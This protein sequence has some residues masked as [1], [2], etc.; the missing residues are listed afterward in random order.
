[1]LKAA[2]ARMSR[3]VSN[4]V[5]LRGENHHQSGDVLTFRLSDGLLRARVKG[6][7]HQIYDV[8]MD[9]KI[10]PDAAS[11]CGCERKVNCEHAV[12]AL[13]ALHARETGVDTSK[14]S[15]Q[16]SLS[17]LYETVIKEDDVKWYSQSRSEG[18]DFFSYHLG[19]L[20]DKQPVSIVPLVA[21]LL[22]QFGDALESRDDTER[23]RLPIAEGKVLEVTL[24]RLKPLL[25][26]LWQYGLKRKDIKEDVLKLTR[27]QLL[28]MQEAEQAI[29]ASA[30]RW[31]GTAEFRRIHT[32]LLNPEVVPDD[33]IPKGLNANLRAYQLEGLHWLQRLRR[34]KL[35]GILADDMG[36]GKTLQALAHLQL[37]KEAGR[38]RR[39]SLILAPTSVLGNWYEEAKRFTP[40][41]KVLVYH[42]LARHQMRQFDEYDLIISTYGVV[43]RDKAFFVKYMFYYLVLDE[44][45]VIKNT[46]TKTRQIIQQL[47]SKH[48]LCLTGT[49]LENHL[50]ELWSLFH[51]L[52]PGFL[53]TQK[54]FR[55]FF[56]HPIEKQ[57]D[58]AVRSSLVRRLQPFVLRR[59]KNQVVSELPQKTEVTRKI[60][61]VGFQ[62]DLYET[63][64]MTTERSVREA[65]VKQGLNKSQWV[66]L[67]ALLKLRQ[68]CCDPRLLDKEDERAATASAKLDVCLELLD[69]LMDE[70]RSVLV[71]SQFTSMLALIEEALIKRGYNYLTL[72]GKTRNRTEIVQKF[73]AGE[74]PIFLIS[75]RAGGV[76]LNL[77]RADTVIHYDPWWNPAVEDQATDRTHR[78]GQKKPVFVY[79][80]I[81]AGTVEEVMMKM[82]KQKRALFDSI[83]SEETLSAPVSWTEEEV[84]Q[85][86]M[87]LEPL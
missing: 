69:N 15:T 40:D 19:I 36:L 43:Q 66:F 25:R 12:A 50:G 84:A 39:A 32:A 73:Q 77:T 7:S 67:E 60:D 26:L 28:F 79:R 46:Q 76:G 55:Q 27:Y 1:M 72:T 20:I 85:F 11:R 41:L 22:E 57:Q 31:Q 62:R 71:F 53:G 44:A 29:A 70:G 51:F 6:H 58:E 33:V 5:L 18:H 86:F 64:R 45:Q 37:E 54:Q 65:I 3:A 75:L 59:N 38:L 87:P 74:A 63:I 81:G 35:N 9:L 49:P 10:F 52:A 21:D 2:I 82:Q 68:V 56:Q 13:L 30:A 80:L 16:T 48:R 4:P 78:I 34:S 61:L 23:F 83:F 47:Q 8:Y 24:G 17:P 14:K 42:G